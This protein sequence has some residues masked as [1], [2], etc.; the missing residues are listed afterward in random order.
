MVARQWQGKV[1]AFHGDNRYAPTD[2]RFWTGAPAG[3]RAGI[4]GGYAQ[5]TRVDAAKRNSKKPSQTGSGGPTGG[6]AVGQGQAAA[7]PAAP[8][9]RDSGYYTE[10]AKLNFQKNQQLA[11]QQTQGT[12]ERADMEKALS[13]QAEQRPKDL[14]KANESFNK[15]GLFYSGK[16]GEARGDIEKGHSRQ[17]ADTRERFA[18]SE[19]AREAA[20]RALEEGASIDAAAALAASVDRQGGR[21]LQEPP[22]DV[23]GGAAS[24]AT[25]GVNN[26]KPFRIVKHQGWIYHKYESGKTVKVRRA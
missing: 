19:A 20:R 5:A 7:A 14:Q 1:P 18:R 6:P 16:L 25:S 9:P 23:A 21:D 11:Q 15:S 3:S 12:Y 8:D 17:E 26:G 24:R 13:R 10:I 22:A 2:A 4:A